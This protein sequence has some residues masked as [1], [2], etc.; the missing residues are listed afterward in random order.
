[1]AV[2]PGDVLRVVAHFA[3]PGGIVLNTYHVKYSGEV[4]VGN[5]GFQ[6][7]VADVLDDCYGSFVSDLH[8][9]FTFEKI[10]FW[11]ITQDAPLNDS[12]WPTLIDGGGTG[13][14][15]PAQ[16]A[17]L[18]KFGTAVARSQGRKYLSGFNGSAGAADS[19]IDNTAVSHVNTGTAM[20][21]GNI[22]AGDGTF[23]FG[24]YR[25]SDGRF[26]QWNTRETD[27][28]FRTQRRRTYGVGL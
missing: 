23:A 16:L 24:N 5:A 18:V 25:Y 22:A 17:V 2:Q 19:R 27:Y 9:N 1:M 11:N 13:N 21:L 3:T 10:S 15:L 12:D 4:E 14:M 7:A 8:E 20:L 28:E 6:A 26:A